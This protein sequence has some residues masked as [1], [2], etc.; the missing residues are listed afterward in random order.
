MDGSELSLYP[1]LPHRALALALT[2]PSGHFVFVAVSTV[3][4][5]Y[6]QQNSFGVVAHGLFGIFN[7]IARLVG[8]G[9][10]RPSAPNPREPGGLNPPAI[11]QNA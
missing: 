10:L 6:G 8:E 5:G 3:F 11:G 2:D 9:K 4:H 7:G 1:L